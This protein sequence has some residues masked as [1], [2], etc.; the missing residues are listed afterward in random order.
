M[1]EVSG[2]VKTFTEGDREIRPLDGIDFSCKQGEF[3]IITG[4]SGSGKTTFLNIL[5]GLAQPTIGSVKIDGAEIGRLSDAGCSSLRFRTIG[6]VFQFPGLLSSLSVLENVTLPFS[7]AGTPPDTAYARNLL[8][9]VGLPDKADACPARLSGG[10]LKRVAIARAL[11]NKPLLILADEPTAELDP[12]T[13]RDVMA[14]LCEA[15]R[16]GTTI[17]LVTHSTEQ[18]SSATRVLKM[19]NGRLQELHR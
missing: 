10:E 5:G 13:E 15:N 3:V 14:L 11:V 9:R 8:K 1:I 17:V 6:F 16:E 2:L 19:E 4:R 7:L 12:D 18:V